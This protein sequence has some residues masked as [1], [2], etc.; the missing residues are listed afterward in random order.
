MTRPATLLLVVLA[1]CAA[2]RTSADTATIPCDRDNTLYENASGALSNG[3]GPTMFSGRTNQLSNSRRRA[4]VHFDIASAVPAGSTITAVSLTL[5]ASM[6]ASPAAL[7][8]ALQK[9][10]AN[11]GEGT[12]NAGDPGGSGASSTTGDATWNHRFFSTLLWTT[13]GGDFAA[14]ASAVLPVEDTGTWT[15]VSTPALVA[16]VQGWLTAPATNFGWLLKGDESIAGTTKR[17]DTRE[18]I[19]PLARP[20]LRVDY[21]PQGTPA[22]TATW[23]RIKASYRR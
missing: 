2:G 18:A 23:G 11:W 8:V 20:S 15:W 6:V 7:P 3:K 14:V 5:N 12:S 17:F 4:L 22:A 19:D 13:P 21:T 16:D 9:V 10:S 1:L